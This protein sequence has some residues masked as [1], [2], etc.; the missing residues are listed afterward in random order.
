MMSGPQSAK[1]KNKIGLTMN[2]DVNKYDV[3]TPKLPVNSQS[4]LNNDE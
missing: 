4:K 3:Q 2:F 1:P